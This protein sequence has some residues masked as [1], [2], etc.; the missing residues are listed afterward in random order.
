MVTTAGNYKYLGRL[1]ATFDGSGE[2]TSIGAQS[3]P[4]RVVPTGTAATTLGI[5]DAVTP[6]AR[7]QTQAVDPVNACVAALSNPF[8]DTE[9]LFDTSNPGQRTRESNTGNSVADSFLASYDTYA[10]ANGLA[11]RSANNRVIAVQN[12]GG[13]RQNAGNVLPTTGVAPGS[14]S[15]KN[16]GDV[17]AFFNTMSV[18]EGVDPSE[19]KSIM[20]WSMSALPT[21]NGKFLQIGGFKITYDATKP[22]QQLLG[23]APSQ[24]IDPANPGQRI[25]SITLADG[26]PIVADGAVVPG[27]PTVSIVTNR[28]TAEGGDAF[29]TLR[30]NT[31]RTQLFG[32]G[33]VILTY[34]QAWIDYL[35]SF[36]V[37]VSGRPTIPASDGRY[38]ATTGEGRITVAP[39]AP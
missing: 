27:A 9:V 16:T 21:A 33:G 28:F 31:D 36:P 15:K 26:T 17:L 11:A 1:D 38:A 6:D 35:A 3:G 2:I 14:I 29:V 30:D 39:P 19:L 24:T 7:V 25:R 5:T 23:S 12:G 10:A 4:V 32:T 22:A 8:V 34:E 20:E 37:G 18:T 13:I